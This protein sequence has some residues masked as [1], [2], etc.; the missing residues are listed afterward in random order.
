MKSVQKRSRSTSLRWVALATLVVLPVGSARGPSY[1]SHRPDA[2]ENT[3]PAAWIL[4]QQDDDD[5]SQH[6]HTAEEDDDFDVQPPAI[7]IAHIAQALTLT[8]HL[9]QKIQSNIVQPTAELSKIDKLRGGGSGGVWKL[10]LQAPTS[11]AAPTLFH[12]EVR[13]RRPEL[14]SFVQQAVQVLS[15][16]DDD[17]NQALE[18]TLAML[19]LDRACSLNVVRSPTTKACPFS[20]PQTVH[21]LLL[22]SLLLSAMAVRGDEERVLLRKVE[23]VFGVPVDESAAMVEWMRAAQG[24]VGTFVTPQEI[25]EFRRFWERQF[26]GA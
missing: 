25:R 23:D 10:P 3:I 7:S 21:R 17:E 12:G 13:R 19:Y 2:F 15:D 11:T 8:T 4:S 20:T 1:A 22:T 18:L 24:E 16:D 14:E 26:P 5:H 6:I 9:N